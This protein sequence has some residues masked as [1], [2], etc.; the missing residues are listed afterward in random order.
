[1]KA[2]E[3]EI[4]IRFMDTI[5]KI[6]SESTEATVYADKLAGL[7]RTRVDKEL[8]MFLPHDIRETNF[9]FKSKKEFTKKILKDLV[10]EDN[11]ER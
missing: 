4:R 1:M 7:I 8:V 6:K 3:G 9:E 10:R 2:I 5:Q 11:F